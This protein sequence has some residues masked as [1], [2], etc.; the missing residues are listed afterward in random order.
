MTETVLRLRADAYY[1]PVRDG[2]W[3]RTTAGSFTLRGPNAAAW[4]QQLAPL[5]DQGVQPDRLFAALRPDQ[6]DYVRKLIGALESRQVLRREP[7]EPDGEPFPQQLE[8]LRHQSPD[9]RAALR[10][11]A[12]TP[13]A[14]AG[15]PARATAL[16]AALAETGFTDLALLE[17][18]PDQ[19]LRE[20]AE[21]YA[22]RGRPL[23]LT[24]GA[25]PQGRAVVGVFGSEQTEQAFALADGAA[26]A[27]HGAWLALVRGQ[28]MLL[29]GQLPG[30]GTACLRC[31]WRR[32]VHSAVGLAPVP[33]LGH[34][35]VAVAAAV[36]AQE[37]FQ[38]AATG[39]LDRLGEGVVVDLTRLSIWRTTV[40]PDP[41]CPAD[42]V[43]RGDP[44]PAPRAGRFPDQVFA[45]RCF[46]PLVSCAPGGYP[47]LPLTVVRLE[48]SVPD[49]QEPAPGGAG[50]L[51]AAETMADARHEAVLLAVRSAVAGPDDLVE[52]GTDRAEAVGRALLRRADREIGAGWSAA[53]PEAG[54]ADRDRWAALAGTLPP[55]LLERHPSGLWRA[56]VPGHP[57]RT[58]LDAEHAQQRALLAALGAAQLPGEAAPVPAAAARH[59]EP[60]VLAG[61]LD[62]LGCSP[63]P[64]VLPPLV[65]A[66]LVGVAL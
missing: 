65:A 24:A 61:L 44:P 46:G 48:S 50:Q 10:R 42:Q 58:G 55:V 43:H 14:V 13:V 6:L 33:G 7:A 23:R 40:D 45:A 62:A 18:E 38:H 41:G 28:A 1:M 37:L 47:Q 15:D 2:V 63:R 12:D 29:K 51:L 52:V 30:S 26:A 59:P 3:I 49:R 64:V 4:V 35:Q 31:A 22:A 32:L 17:A 53:G 25:A 20:L 66:H 21:E 34:T 27:G 8:F 39:A 54:A 57:P 36:L 16:A 19:R 60:A 9:A 56:T 11:V 5:L